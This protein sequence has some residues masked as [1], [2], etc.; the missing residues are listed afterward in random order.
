MPLL[1]D[2]RKIFLKVSQEI[3]L[4]KGNLIT[5][6]PVVKKEYFVSL[7]LW[8]NTHSGQRRNVFLM[9]TKD[10]TKSTG[11]HVLGLWITPGNRLQIVATVNGETE[12]YFHTV[13]ETETWV[14]INVE[15][16]LVDD[17]VWEFF[18]MLNN[19]FTFSTSIKS[20]L[21]KL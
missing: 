11:I 4:T 13:L 18:T 9:T 3:Q 17:K 1:S 20:G 10:M 12:G 15:Q 8:L 19:S 6:L 7:D 21:I 14:E 2:V 5:V 16:A